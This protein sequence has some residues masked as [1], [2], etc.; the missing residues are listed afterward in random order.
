[1]AQTL[2]LRNTRGTGGQGRADSGRVLPRLR[3]RVPG[4][5]GRNRDPERRAVPRR[6]RQGLA[7]YSRAQCQPRARERAD[8]SDQGTADDCGQRRGGW[9]TARTPAIT[10]SGAPMIRAFSCGENALSAADESAIS[11]AWVWLD[12]F[13]PTPHEERLLESR[14]GIDIPTQEEMREIEISSRLY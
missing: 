3:R 11:D 2:H 5:S 10:S 1:M 7:L 12:L 6:R 9:L 8:R 14:L 4:D 13:D